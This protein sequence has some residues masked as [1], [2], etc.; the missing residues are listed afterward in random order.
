MKK[1]FWILVTF[2]IVSIG[3]T[4]EVKAEHKD[5]ER[6]LQI[7]YKERSKAMITMDYGQITP[8]YLS[9]QKRSQFALEHEKQR[10]AYIHAWGSKRNLSFID[11]ECKIKIGHIKRVGNKAKIFLIQSQTISYQHQGS[12]FNPQ[13]FGIGTRHFLTLEQKDNK[14]YLVKE[15]YLD[16]LEENINL[17]PVSKESVT[18]QDLPAYNHDKKRRKYNRKRAVSYAEKYA[19]SASMA[20]NQNRYNPK[21][22]DYTYEGGDCTNFTSQVLGDPTEGG[23]LP[24]RGKWFYQKEGSV[25]WI[26]TDALYQFLIYSGYGRLITRG[27]YEEVAKPNKKFPQAALSQLKPGDLIAYELEGNI[28]HFSIVTSRDE[29]GYILVNSHSA[30]RYH[31]PWDLGWDNK[32]KFYLIHIN[33]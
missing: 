21:Y 1:I 19:G 15:W 28:D 11:A 6:L 22:A 32:T 17:I 10:S 14:W 29:Q 7:M 4:K 31:V 5:I 3:N 18:K 24:M 9:T 23:G 2:V 30:D 33:D 27:T 8:Y 25:A 20:G 13:K 16:P 12:S 26:R